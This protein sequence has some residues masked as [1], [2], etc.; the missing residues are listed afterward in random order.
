MKVKLSCFSACALVSF[1][2]SV[3]LLPENVIAINLQTRS[4]VYLSEY[5]QCVQVCLPGS[6]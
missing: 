1:S 3:K 4:R 6:R 2:G 5:Q